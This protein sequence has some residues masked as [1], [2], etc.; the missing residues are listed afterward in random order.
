[1]SEKD[2]NIED[3]T[4][5]LVDKRTGETVCSTDMSIGDEGK[6]ANNREDLLEQLHVLDLENNILYSEIQEV[7]KKILKL[8]KESLDD[9]FYDWYHYADKTD[10]SWVISRDEASILR[11]VTDDWL[12]R[13]QTV[14]VGELLDI[15]EN[16]EVEDVDGFKKELMNLNFGSMVYDW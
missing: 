11:G 15:I 3:I 10:Y 8:P 2:F 6:V 13:Y 9:A 16:T 4:F 12:E 1:M 7:K 5:K 14:D